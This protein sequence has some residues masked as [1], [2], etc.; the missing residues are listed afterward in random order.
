MLKAHVENPAAMSRP[1]VLK[2]LLP[3]H[4][5]RLHEVGA[6]HRDQIKNS[7]RVLTTA[8][9]VDHACSIV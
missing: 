4:V 5:S 7:V 3:V 9:A 8:D 6:R 1:G 2:S